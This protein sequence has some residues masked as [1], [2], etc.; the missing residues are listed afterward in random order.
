VGVL[1]PSTRR[2]LL[3]LAA[4]L[5]PASAAYDASA[6]EACL[7]LIDETL[8]SRPAAL[9]RQVA[10]VLLML[11]WAPALR[12]GRPLD[13]LEAGAQDLVL[14]WFQRCPVQAVRTGFWGVRTLVFLGCYGRPGAGVALGYAPSFDGHAVLHAR[15]GR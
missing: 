14:R 13:R 4:R 8:A 5:V 1:T 11:R 6:R 15:T 12:F 9:R 2:F 7:R 10:L 3:V